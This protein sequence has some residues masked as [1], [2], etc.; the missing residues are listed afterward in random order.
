M[1]RI[2]D[3]F[4]SPIAGIRQNCHPNINAGVLWQSASHSNAGCYNLTELLKSSFSTI[5]KLESANKVLSPLLRA[6][7]DQRRFPTQI[8]KV[9]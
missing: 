3:A 7:V 4:P 1:L 9:Q 8:G 2:G 6:V 5:N